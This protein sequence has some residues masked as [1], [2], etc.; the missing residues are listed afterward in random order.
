MLSSHPYTTVVARH[1]PQVYSTGRANLPGSV[2]ERMLQKSWRDM[3]PELLA[4]STAR[5]QLRLFPEMQDFH[6]VLEE[7]EESVSA[8]ETRP[9][10]KAVFTGWEDW[11]AGDDG[12]GGGETGSAIDDG[13]AKDDIDDDTLGAL[14]L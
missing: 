14:G 3:L 13:D 10:D 7:E 4:F 5:A 9:S 2:V 8:E 1:R 12:G 6:A 11:A